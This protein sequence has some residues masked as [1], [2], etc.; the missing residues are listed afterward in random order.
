MGL[1]TR[2]PFSINRNNMGKTCLDKLSSGIAVGCTVPV[3]GVKNIYLMHTE[4]VTFTAASWGILVT[5][6]F[7]ATGKSY[8][9]EGYKQNIQVTSAIRTMDASNKLDIS[10]MFKMP[11]NTTFMRSL[12]TG[13]FYVMVEYNDLT[14]SMVGYTSPLECTGMD[15]DSNANGKLYTITLTAPDGS[16]GNYYTPVSPEAITTI[17]SK[18]V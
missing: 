6:T 12:L 7:T 16:S 17:I 15:G 1:K 5:A 8:K 11:A 13:R 9:V 3:N 10:V 14:Y 4:D 18:A 2:T